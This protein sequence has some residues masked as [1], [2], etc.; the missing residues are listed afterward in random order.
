MSTISA[1]RGFF[2][3]AMNALIES[4]QREASRYVSGVL[5]GFDDKTLKAHGYDREELKKTARS[6]YV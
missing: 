6:P 3:S 1:R 4:R 5:L 2:R